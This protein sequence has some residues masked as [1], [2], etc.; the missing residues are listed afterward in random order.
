[1]KIN[2]TYPL[3]NPTQG[4]KKRTI[5]HDLI[6]NDFHWFSLVF[7]GFHRFFI[8]FHGFWRAQWPPEFLWLGK[9]WGRLGELSGTLSR[10]RSPNK[11]QFWAQ[12]AW[13]T[14][15]IQWFLPFLA[16]KCKSVCNLFK[17]TTTF[18]VQIAIY[19]PCYRVLFRPDSPRPGPIFGGPRGRNPQIKTT[20][21]TTPNLGDFWRAYPTLRT[22]VP[23]PPSRAHPKDDARSKQLPQIRY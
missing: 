16:P 15:R 22:S 23:T 14:I 10:S 12:N 8:G 6:F 4:H 19:W 20:I 2:E 21:S 3:S 5:Q 11:S 1:M 17:I 13:K 18:T 7:I 9:V